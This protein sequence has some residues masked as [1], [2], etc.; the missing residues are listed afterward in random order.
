MR[1]RYIAAAM[2]AAPLLFGSSLALRDLVG[3]GPAADQVGALTAFDT[4]RSNR[5]QLAAAAHSAVSLIFRMRPGSDFLYCFRFDTDTREFHRGLVLASAEQTR[6][7]LSANLKSVQAR[8]GTFPASMLDAI[9]ARADSVQ[10]P[11]IVI[12]YGDGENSDMSRDA[13]GSIRSSAARLA[14][15]PNCV[16]V[17]MLGAKPETWAFWTETFAALGDRF[18]PSTTFDGTEAMRRLEAARNR[19]GGQNDAT[20]TR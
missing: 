6:T 4:S 11:F 17:A 19:E 2:A 8:D 12:I 14:K 7:L 5:A 18:M 9:A 3:A 1:K 10:H 13:V 20:P 15:N 16:G